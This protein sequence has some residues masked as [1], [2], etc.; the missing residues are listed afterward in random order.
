MMQA[1][2]RTVSRSLAQCELVHVARQPFNLELAK[3]QHAAYVK[4]LRAT[5]VDVTVLPEE[6]DLPDATFVEDTMI[7]LDELAVLCRP[8]AKSRQPEV[9]KI[10]RAITGVR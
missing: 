10:E 3:V 5:G 8:G 6:P 7:V 9:K 2:V 1:L 4:A